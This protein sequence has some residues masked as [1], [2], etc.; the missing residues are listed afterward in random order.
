MEEIGAILVFYINKRLNF[1]LFIAYMALLLIFDNY[2]AKP[3]S[4]AIRVKYL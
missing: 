1:I 3:L 2:Y 4:K